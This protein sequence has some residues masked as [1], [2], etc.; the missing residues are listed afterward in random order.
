[1]SARKG[2]GTDTDTE[3]LRAKLTS[4]RDRLVAYLKQ[5]DGEATAAKAASD[6]G[7]TKC[8][9]GYVAGRFPAYFGTWR[10]HRG[11]DRRVT[12]HLH[13]HLRLARTA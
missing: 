6:L 7:M 4:D 8:R 2:Y 10:E 1:M 5:H 12:I 13:P 11:H 9:P 3:S